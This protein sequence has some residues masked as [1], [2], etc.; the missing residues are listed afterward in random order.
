MKNQTTKRVGTV[1]EYDA[2]A[3]CIV[4]AV[5]FVA[6]VDPEAFSHIKRQPANKMSDE[7]LHQALHT[8][9]FF[10]ADRALQVKQLKAR[11][12]SQRK[13]NAELAKELCDIRPLLYRAGKRYLQELDKKASGQ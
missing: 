10:A 2:L 7:E 11:G 3:E 6:A 4:E 9:R 8:L 1:Q 13:E 5:F 12:E